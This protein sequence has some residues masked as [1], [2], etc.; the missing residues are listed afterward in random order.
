MDIDLARTFLEIVTSGSF[1]NASKRLNLTQSTVSL[2]VKRLEELLGKPV[3]IRSK[4]GVELTPAG[5]QFERFAR[6]M[7]KVWEEAKHQ[8]AVPDGY[9][10]SLIVGSQYSLWPKFSMRWLRL[11]ERLM[12]EVALRAEMGNPD[13]LIRMMLDGVLDI[14]LMYTPQLR[15]GLEVEVIMEDSLVLAS[16]DPD[17]TDGLDENYVFIDWGPE[18]VQAHKTYF[19]DF[20]TSHVVLA[21]GTLSARYV[22][23]H[24][25]SAYF[26]AR[27]IE[28]EVEEGTLA[29]VRGAP[30]FPFPVYAVWHSD[31]DAELVARALT[32]LRRVAG[33]VE[34]D[35]A[36]LLEDAGVDQRSMAPR[37][38]E[39]IEDTEADEAA[40]S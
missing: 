27:F 5:E 36:L 10:K 32:T 34:D 33:R 38:I 31:A 37:L 2:R 28:D 16:C 30:V 8:V 3:F 25:R 6:S 19:P 20:R 9:E 39:I 17:H 4:S 1:M 11:L 26:P 35:Q 14:A 7:L 29:V 12:P 15:P 23:A 40:D 13:R 22:V 24:Q 18:F 21:L